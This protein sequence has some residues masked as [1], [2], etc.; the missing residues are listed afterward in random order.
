MTI[1]I[2]SP[3]RVAI[4]LLVL[5]AATPLL[6]QNAPFGLPPRSAAP[7]EAG[8]WAAWLLAQ[9][10]AFHKAMVTAF[11]RIGRDPAAAASL[12]GLAFA[13]GVVHAIGPG[14]GKAVIAGYLVANERALRRGIGLAFGAAGVQALVALGVV[15]LVAGLVGGTAQRIDATIRWVELAGF[16]LILAMGLWIVV[17]KV[18]AL[19]APDGSESACEPDCGH[20]HGPAPAKLA[21]ASRRDLILT[22][23][24]AGIRPCAGAIILLVFALTK[25]LF[26]IGAAAVAAMAIGTAIGTSAFAALAVYAKKFALRLIE[27]RAGWGR[28]AIL[29][30][31]ALAGVALATLGGLM[32]TGLM[33]AGA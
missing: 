33:T 7:P 3:L 16:G 26:L 5:A 21:A 4:A 17:R 11:S 10:A 13:Y 31:E 29:A 6:A 27:G 14:H 1:S 15:G 28:K 23:I 30:L 18:R 24:G 20:D 25:G 32:L 19:L 2:G 9:Q 8:G 22:A 12:L